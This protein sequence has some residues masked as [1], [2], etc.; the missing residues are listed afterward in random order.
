[1]IAPGTK[2]SHED[3]STMMLHH[4]LLSNGIDLTDYDLVPSEDV[5]FIVELIEGML[6]CLRFL[7]LFVPVFLGGFRWFLFCFV[8]S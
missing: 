3:G 4:L 8:S 1:V 6:V 2:W 5:P 7:T